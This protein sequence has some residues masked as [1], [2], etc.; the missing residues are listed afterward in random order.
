LSSGVIHNKP[1]IFHALARTD[2]CA[3]PVLAKEAEQACERK[4]I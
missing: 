4:N 2:H 3:N 1:L